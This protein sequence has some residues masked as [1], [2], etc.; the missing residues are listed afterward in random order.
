MFR[1]F[2]R[3][4][5]YNGETFHYRFQHMYSSVFCLHTNPSEMIY[6]KDSRAVGSL[7]AQPLDVTFKRELKLRGQ[8]F[9]ELRGRHH[10]EYN[11]LIIQRD[12]TAEQT[13][14][15]HRFSNEPIIKLLSFPV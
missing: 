6:F 2:V 14:A 9:T 8:R 11:G 10:F 13:E 12:K 1:I 3:Y 5:D 4:I 15:R 7:E